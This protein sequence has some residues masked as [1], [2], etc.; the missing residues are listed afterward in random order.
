M[1][2]ASGVHL[3]R[4]LAHL[5]GVQTAY[6]D[7]AHFRRQVSVDALLAILKSLGAPLIT[8]QDVPSA[9]RQR[10]QALWQQPIEPVAV[11]WN[12]R[13]ASIEVRLPAA[14]ADKSIECHL[15]GGDLPP[16]GAEEVEGTRYVSKQLPLPEGLSWG[17]HRFSMELG[18]SVKE[19][20]IISAPVKA[21]APA[22]ESCI[23]A[24]GA[25]VPLYALHTRNSWGGG[26][27][28][29]LE[30]LTSWIARMGGGVA[31]TLPLL[32]TFYDS[33][34][35]V[36]P[37]LPVSRRLWN[38]FYLDVS[39]V[40]EL[41][42]CPA[43]QSV[44]AS[45]QFQEDIKALRHLPLVDYRRQMALKRRVLEELGRC[46]FARP[47]P[48]LEALRRFTEDN[49]LV[50]DYARFRATGEKQNT[51][52][53][54]WPQPPRDGLLKD[55]D[56][57]EENRRYHLYVQ[58][59]A[60]QQME[61]LAKEAKDR[62]VRLYLDLPLGV[63]PDGYDVWREQGAFLLDVSAGAP[64]D[65]VFTKGQNWTSPPLHPDK[66]REQGYQYVID[67]LRHHL[68]QASI[69]RIDHVMGL[70][71]LFCIPNGMEARQGTYLRYR[72]DE[73]YAILALESHR[74]KTIIVG[75]D[76][77]TV[78]HYIRPAMNRHGLNRMYVL[79]YEL[80]SDIQKGLPSVPGNA[81]A[82]L[83]THDMSP[84][85]AFW[86]GYD[87][88]QRLDLGLLDKAGARREQR[89]RR[90]IKGV[91]NKFLAGKG[92]LR[93]NE[94][95]TARALKGCLSFLA[96]SKAPVVLVNLEDLWLETQPQN[97]PSTVNN[98]PNWQHKARYSFEE[99]CQ[100]PQVTDTLR[101]INKLREQGRNKK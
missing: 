99:F 26:D 31:A 80:I 42:S 7:V 71:R 60:H 95:D 28:S 56:Y 96:A 81:I 17:Y 72:A 57:H 37:Y 62:G 77:G 36:S 66:T 10:R 64:P 35:N 74:H 89:T 5:Y 61:S 45:A 94:V 84:F 97:V 55:N 40:P 101:N 24:W 63:H 86:R 13:L 65:A 85:A 1:T 44:I 33:D 87:I 70:H 11:A 50:A 98:Y 100:M 39:R 41:P 25:F 46:L 27:F 30:A 16:T 91:L 90:D 22:R 59:L 48:R 12:G 79:H 73:L 3:L 29:D 83:N 43:A 32:P 15:K 9:W 76:L 52:W 51:T 88:Q 18:G 14:I 23:G 2:A 54:S 21:Y 8:V 78:P 4:K 20:L 6:Y 34:S 67:Y 38:E 82:S 53:R 47:S 49:A 93:E 68:K 92:W 58:W 69:L 75:E 19:A